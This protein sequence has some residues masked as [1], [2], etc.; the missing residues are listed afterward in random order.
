MAVRV[1]EEFE[2]AKK[3]L[4]NNKPELAAF[5]AG[6]MAH[7]LGD[8]SQFMHLMGKQ[9][10]WKSENQKFH[11]KYEVV[12]DKNIDAANRASKIFASY[13]KK[14]GV[15]GTT[16]STITINLAKFTETGNNSAVTTG[17]MYDMWVDLIAHGKSSKVGNWPQDFMDQSGANVNASVN[18]VAE[19]LKMLS[20]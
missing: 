5:Y 7:Y 3:A 6:A 18:A 4:A 10:H 2:K 15:G 11:H 8:L 9:S 1:N 14:K 19:L 12:A 16:P 13:I 17:A 20:Q